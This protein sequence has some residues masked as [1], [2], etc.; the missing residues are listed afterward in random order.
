MSRHSKRL[1]FQHCTMADSADASIKKSIGMAIHGV[2][3]QNNGKLTAEVLAEAIKLAMIPPEHHG[4]LTP[5]AVY[6]AVKFA[7]GAQSH[8]EPVKPIN[9]NLSPEA[10]GAALKTTF[11]EHNDEKVSTATTAAISIVS[12]ETVNK[13]I[14]L[15]KQLP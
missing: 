11:N 3:R 12:V 7:N 10:L 15:A 6:A 9:L 8:D 1:I 5:V 4:K 2:E 13:A 14:E